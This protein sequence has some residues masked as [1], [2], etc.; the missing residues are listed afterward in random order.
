MKYANFKKVINKGA[1]KHRKKLPKSFK[2]TQQRMLR[3]RP[4]KRNDIMTKA[5]AI[6]WRR[7]CNHRA[8][9]RATT[10]RRPG[11]QEQ[12]WRARQGRHVGEGGWRWM[13]KQVDVTHLVAAKRLPIRARSVTRYFYKLFLLLF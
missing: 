6:T 9:A 5:R 1:F 4:R 3:G 11:M 7:P 10:G 8:A 13:G 2:A 12:G